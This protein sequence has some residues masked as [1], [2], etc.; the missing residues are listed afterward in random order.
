LYL[1]TPHLVIQN[2]PLL[3]K[4]LS[5]FFQKENQETK[6]NENKNLDENYFLIFLFLNRIFSE[7]VAGCHQMT[8]TENWQRS[9]VGGW[10]KEI[11]GVKSSQQ[12]RGQTPLEIP[13]ISGF[14]TILLQRE[15]GLSMD[16]IQLLSL[17]SAHPN[18]DQSLLKV[19][20]GLN[21]LHEMNL[22]IFPKK[23]QWKYLARPE[24]EFVQTPNHLIYDD[25]YAGLRYD[26]VGLPHLPSLSIFE[27]ILIS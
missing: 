27:S 25:W 1:T 23:I 4:E 16:A 17:F 21:R 8:L 24:Y 13:S 7:D 20:S 22:S 18:A 2:F 3:F 14:S 19:M 5:Q 15:Y 26:Q 6:T 11:A 12:N 10:M 9:K